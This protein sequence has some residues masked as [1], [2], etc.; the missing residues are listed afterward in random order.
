MHLPVYI[1][2]GGQSRRFG[3]NKARAVCGGEL[4]VR[5][6][7]RQFEPYSAGVTVVARGADAYA[8]L[9]LRTIADREPG[10]GPAGGLFTALMD[11]Q[12]QQGAGWLWLVSCD[13]VAVDAKLL[14]RLEA[15]REQAE[16]A[17]ALRHAHWEP[18]P[19][20]YH[21]SIEPGV[22]AFLESGGRA[23]QK[24][25]DHVKATALRAEPGEALPRQFNTAAELEAA[26]PWD[27]QQPSGA[28]DDA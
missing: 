9:G 12:A 2:A 16:H 22:R 18:M 28:P 4:M 19:G 10:L 20:L 15:A 17:V 7:A 27:K 13:L 24:L 8:D 1:L 23:M 21:T 26:A 11:R 25:L 6:V 14:R 3:S 5:R